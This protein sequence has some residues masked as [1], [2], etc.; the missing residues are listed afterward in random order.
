MK[1][2]LD[3]SIKDVGRIVQTAHATL[4]GVFGENSDVGAV[5]VLLIADYMMETRSHRFTCI[6]DGLTSG[7]D[8]IG[9]WIV[10]IG[11]VKGLR[12]MTDMALKAIYGQAHFSSVELRSSRRG[13]HVFVPAIDML[14]H[15]ETSESAPIGAAVHRFDTGEANP[16]EDREPIVFKLPGMLATLVSETYGK[17]RM[18]IVCEGIRLA[19]LQAGPYHIVIRPFTSIDRVLG[20]IAEG[21]AD[22]AFFLRGGRRRYVTN[23]QMPFILANPDAKFTSLTFTITQDKDR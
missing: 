3:L 18:R 21:L 7:E 19:D 23:G 17:R 12:R 16:D 15:P 8:D 1:S 2:I 6:T 13:C 20:K 14:E 10:S 22:L 11:P 9:D 4:P 5:V